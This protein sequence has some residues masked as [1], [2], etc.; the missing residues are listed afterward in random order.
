M[1]MVN[2]RLGNAGQELFRKGTKI[3]LAIIGSGDAGRGR[4]LDSG[5]GSFVG[6]NP[7]DGADEV[8][9]RAWLV[10]KSSALVLDQFGNSGDG[11]RQHQFFVSHG[12]HQHYWDSLAFAGHYDQV[13]V[14]VV[15][16]K[17]G[18]RHLTDQVNTPLEPRR[19]NLTFESRALRPLADDPAEEVETLVAKRGASLDQEAV[20]LHL[21]QASDREET[22]PPV[23][24]FGGGGGYGPGKHAIDPKTLHD[25][26]FRG[27]R[28]V[29][30][31]N[32]LAVEIRDRYTEL[33][34]T[35]LGR[36]QLRALQQIRPVQGETEADSEQTGSG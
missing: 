14:A 36:E 13:G 20:V 9:Q 5:E 6:L 10:K 15:A 30:A 3:S 7:T 16:G 29:V 18:A 4:V 1:R 31:E 27:R 19:H 28:R 32:V 12:F 35:Q 2:L 25:N 33:A 26:F 21:M 34:S 11:R 17:V 24:R 22:E 8:G 23:V